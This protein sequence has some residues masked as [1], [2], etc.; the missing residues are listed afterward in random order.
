MF[1]VIKI[2]WLTITKAVMSSLGK[3]YVLM[4]RRENSNIVAV[5]ITDDIFAAGVHVLFRISL[6]PV[7][8]AE[9]RA[10]QVGEV[11]SSNCQ[12]ELS[13]KHLALLLLTTACHPSPWCELLMQHVNDT[14][15]RDIPAPG[16]VLSTC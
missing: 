15:V 12:E 7:P 2:L 5:I 13:T 11:A 3:L 6:A 4:S 14:P 9:W 1:I 16:V 8:S 10:G